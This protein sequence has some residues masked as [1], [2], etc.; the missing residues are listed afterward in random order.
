[1]ATL[2]DSALLQ[3]TALLGS[4]FTS[5]VQVETYVESGF[6]LV[7]ASTDVDVEL[8]LLNPYARNLDRVEPTRTANLLREA[9][10]ALERHVT[11]S[12]GQ[13][14]ND[15]LYTHGLKVSQGFA[16]L[17][18]ALGRTIDPLNIA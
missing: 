2:S 5:F 7:V 6:R 12:S 15:Y 3:H 17:S 8:A 10:E 9:T 13:T 16:D 1:M 14:F 4:G 11:D 18:A